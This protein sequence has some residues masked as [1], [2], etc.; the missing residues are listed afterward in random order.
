VRYLDNDGHDLEPQ[1][2]ELRA[3]QSGSVSDEDKAMSLEDI[4]EGT[5]ESNSQ[6]NDDHT[7]NT[8]TTRSSG[9]SSNL[10]NSNLPCGISMSFVMSLLVIIPISFIIAY[11]A[12]P[13][14]NAVA[15]EA[16]LSITSTLSTCLFK[17]A[18]ACKK[19]RETQ[20][21]F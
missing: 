13:L 6:N 21:V 10:N 9:N 20:P 4:A 3:A 11:T 2:S 15:S 12:I 14:A 18:T 5:D 16:L 1:R 7:E 19:T 17:S 8:I